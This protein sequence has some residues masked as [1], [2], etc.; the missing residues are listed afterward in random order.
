MWMFAQCLVKARM[1]SALRPRS[2]EFQNMVSSAC[3]SGWKH[4][5]PCEHA[6][7]VPAW[8]L[9]SS[10]PVNYLHVSRVSPYIPC[11]NRHSAIFHK[12]ILSLNCLNCLYSFEDYQHCSWSQT[13]K[14]KTDT[15][16]TSPDPQEESHLSCCGFRFH[17]SSPHE[18]T[19]GC[20]EVLCYALMGNTGIWLRS[21]W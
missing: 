17:A 3:E 8:C 13:S 14:Q 11:D 12:L 2:A 6:S 7:R 5:A 21:Q 20:W 10:Y 18:I 4:T 1:Q 9:H 15:C 16:K 19:S